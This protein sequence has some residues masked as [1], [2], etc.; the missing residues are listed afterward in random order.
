MDGKACNVCNRYNYCG[1]RCILFE[2][3]KRAN[4]LQ[5]IY[6]EVLELISGDG[7]TICNAM[8]L[9]D[10]SS[11]VLNK[12]TPMVICQ[13]SNRCAEL[14]DYCD[15]CILAYMEKNLFSMH[16]CIGGVIDETRTVNASLKSFWN[17]GFYKRYTNEDNNGVDG[18]STSSNEC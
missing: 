3:F 1:C 18:A 8:E 16:K 7:V 2:H 15:I 17:N 12:P 4:D 10:A 6:E 5:K 14:A 9:L 13:P 11:M